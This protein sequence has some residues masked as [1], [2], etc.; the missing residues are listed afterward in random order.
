MEKKNALKETL[1]KLEKGLKNIFED[2]NYKEFL[3]VMS[4]FHNY[5]FQNCLLIYMQNPGATLVKGYKGWQNEFNRNVK[6]GEKGLKIIRPIIRKNKG[7]KDE[8][9]SVKEY[10]SYSVTTV[11]DISQTEGESLPLRPSY[12]EDIV[13]KVENYEKFKQSLI[14]VSPVPVKEEPIKNNCSGYYSHKTKDITIKE[15]LSQKEYLN[16]LIHEIAHSILHNKDVLKFNE[17]NRKKK[18]V[19]A[20]SIAFVVASHFGFEGEQ[21][22]FHYIASYSSSEEIKEFKESLTTISSTSNKLI[23]DIEKEYNNLN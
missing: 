20:E 19:E 6:K 17:K 14:S 18:E 7:L 11:F 15:G 16:V 12:E 4:K 1:D 22:S 5:S 8:E 2:R 23:E 9:E 3:K 10:L 21:S 13:G